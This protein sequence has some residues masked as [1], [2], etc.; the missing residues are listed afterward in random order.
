M[1]PAGRP[2]CANASG[3]DAGDLASIIDRSTPQLD[4][5]RLV[6]I[7]KLWEPVGNDSR[8]GKSIR[9]VID[10]YRGSG[11]SSVIMFTDGVTTRDDTIAEAGVY[12]GQRGISLFFVG[13]GDEQELRDLKLQDMQVP[14]QPYVGDTILIEAR[15]TGQGYKDLT[16]P[17]VLTVKTADGKE[18]ELKR[19][20]VKVDPAGKSTKIRLHDHAEEEDRQCGT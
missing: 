3:G 2:S 15:L 4:R 17:I 5:G 9:H 6:A 10:H 12:A 1:P 18:V 8:L 16:V 7:A 19:I 11:L 14:D 20:M 13:V